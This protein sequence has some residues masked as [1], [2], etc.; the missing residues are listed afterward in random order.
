MGKLN[1]TPWMGIED[2]KV[3]MDQ[4]VERAR[5]AARAPGQGAGVEPGYLW[6]PA[7]D[8]VETPEAFVITVDV[9][10]IVREDVAVELRGRSLW[11]RGERRFVRESSGGLYQMLERSYGPF[12]R[13]F[14]L[15]PNIVRDG[16]TAVMAEGML[17]ITV[18]KKRP[19]KI[20][21]RIPIT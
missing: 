2:I 21:R 6:S 17:E 16:V 14:A 3:E 1:W 13:R 15:P 7:A 11:I 20:K 5:R 9:P 4:A 8:I 12:A 18:P 10:G 19:E